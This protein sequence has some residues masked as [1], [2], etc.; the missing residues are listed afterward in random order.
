MPTG[1]PPF[2]ARLERFE[3]IGSTNDAVRDRLEAGEPE[4]CVAVADEQTAGRGRAGRTWTAPP[5]AALLLSAGFRPT[6]LPADR[7]WRL[8][9]IVALAMADAAEDVAGLPLGTIHV[10]WPNDLVVV[11]AGPGAA[12]AFGAADEGAAAALARLAAPLEVR[13]LAGILGETEGL[14]TADPRVIVGIG[15]NADWAASAFAPDLAG[16]MTSLREVSG[17]R[18]IDR[19]A[20]L[21]G[22]LDRLETRLEALRGGRFDLAGWAERQVTTGRVVRLEGPGDRVETV[23]ATGVDGLSGALLVEA[24]DGP[25]AGDERAVLVGE[26]THLRLPSAGSV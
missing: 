17:G 19:E 11:A 26:I 5:D 16:S 14:G 4:V 23:R 9:G 6:Y 2:I 1:A 7:A 25:D 13:K 3:R 21:H 24:L 22:F 15:V 8:A 10:K 20:L 18:P 12:F